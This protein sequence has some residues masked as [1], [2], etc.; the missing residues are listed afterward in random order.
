MG[1]EAEAFE[2]LAGLPAFNPDLDGESPPEP[3]RQWRA[4]LA[5]A[6]AVVISSPEYV[7][8][9]PGAL[10]NALD[11]IVSSGEISSKRVGLINA[12]AGSGEF[13]EAQ[14]KETLTVMEARVLFSISL[15]GPLVRRGFDESGKPVEAEII[16]ALTACV[17][18]LIASCLM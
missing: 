8:G 11:W 14:L 16:T 13:A 18:T 5:R 2:G 4:S 17:D 9:V 10:K 7:H 1:V 6:D 12:S 15:P 3:V